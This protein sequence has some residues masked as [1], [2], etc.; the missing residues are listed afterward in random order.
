[1]KINV[2]ELLKVCIAAGLLNYFFVT[3]MGTEEWFGL[4]MAVLVGLFWREPKQENFGKTE[5]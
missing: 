5:G 2:I 3:L 4:M 1:M